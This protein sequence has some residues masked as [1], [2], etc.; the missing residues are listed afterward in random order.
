MRL[1]IKVKTRSKKPGVEKLDEG[2]FVVRVGVAPIEGK[3]NEAVIKALAEN[4]KIAG[5]RIKIL[6]GSTSS[7]KVVEII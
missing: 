1:F 3:A 7:N 4:L 5:W 6:S 2:N